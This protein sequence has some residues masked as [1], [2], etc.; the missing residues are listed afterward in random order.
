MLDKKFNVFMASSSISDDRKRRLERVFHSFR[1][2]MAG[3]EDD[4]DEFLIHWSSLET[5]DVVYREVFGHDPESL[6]KI[7]GK[8]KT[9]FQYCPV[10]GKE[11]AFLVSRRQTG[12]EEVFAG[13]NEANMY[14][15]LRKLRNGISHGYMGLSECIAMAKENIELVRRAVLSMIMRIIGVAASVQAAILGQTGYK[16]KFFPHFILTAKGSFNPGDARQIDGHPEVEAK[17]TACTA[18]PQGERLTLRPTWSFTNKNC[19]LNYTGYELWGD[20]AAKS[21]SQK[22]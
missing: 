9:P 19:A 7:C 8:C 21:W 6:Y 17:C 16:G 2:A 3:T 4:L 10:C 5:L 12:V 20:K 22:M 13:L 11:D 14:D 18:E 15:E 1:R